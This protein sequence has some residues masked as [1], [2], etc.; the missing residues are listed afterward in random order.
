MYLTLN[1]LNALFEFNKALEVEKMFYGLRKYS[2]TVLRP[3][4]NMQL[5]GFVLKVEISN[6]ASEAP[7]SIEFQIDRSQPIL[8][9]NISEEVRL[10]ALDPYFAFL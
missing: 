1:A 2:Q 3:K 8:V 6:R 9:E 4:I 5:I 10:K 7:K